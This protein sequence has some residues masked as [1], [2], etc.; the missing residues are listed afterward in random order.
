VRLEEDRPTT[1]AIPVPESDTLWGLFAALSLMDSDALRAPEAVGLKVTLMLQV[2]PTATL[3]PQVLVCEKS[4]VL[5][6]VSVMPAPLMSS[7]AVPVFCNVTVCAVLLVPTIWLAKVKLVAPSVTAGAVPVPVS[8]TTCG[9]P[10]SGSETVMLPVRTPVAVGVK[11]TLMLQ[12]AA[13]ARV[14]GLT[15]QLLV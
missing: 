14:A 2:T 4:P 3:A 15:G 7:V 1:G 12:L 9:L 5:A 10:G 8:A 6:P 11:L 13:G